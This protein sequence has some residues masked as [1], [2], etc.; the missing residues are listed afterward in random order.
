MTSWCATE[1]TL[2]LVVLHER[3]HFETSPLAAVHLLFMLAVA[4]RGRPDPRVCPYPHPLRGIPYA[5]ALLAVSH[6]AAWEALAEAW[7]VRHEGR[8]YPRGGVVRQALFWTATLTLAS[9]A[10]FL[11]RSGGGES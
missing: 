3:G 6:Q 4:F 2:R 7:V 1:G 11:R 8:S 5:I 9:A 10:F